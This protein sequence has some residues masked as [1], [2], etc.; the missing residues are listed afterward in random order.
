MTK[1]FLILKHKMQLYFHPFWFIHSFQA[2]QDRNTIPYILIKAFNFLISI[3][4]NMQ[5]HI[6]YIHKKKN[7]LQ[8]WNKELNQVLLS[9][10][11]TNSTQLNSLIPHK[12]RIVEFNFTFLT[13]IKIQ[14]KIELDEKKPIL[15][16][17]NSSMFLH[18]LTN[19]QNPV[20]SNEM[21]HL[22]Q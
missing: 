12:I 10:L 8:Q 15:S 22:A 13:S 6:N 19:Q 17:L 20:S 5:N 3:S 7:N 1:I 18:F 14:A 2:L 16:Q 11:S 4:T 21:L 9:H